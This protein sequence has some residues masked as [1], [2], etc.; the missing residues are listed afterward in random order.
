[1]IRLFLTCFTE[2]VSFQLAQMAGNTYF[3]PY[4]EIDINQQKIAV[5]DKYKVFIDG[6]QTHVASRE[7]FSLLPVVNLYELNNEQPR[8]TINKLFSFF[9]PKYD[10]IR[11]DNNVL[12][13][14]T[15]S[16]WKGQYECPVG[17]D[18]Y[19]I[20]A[21]RGRKYSIY[22]NDQQIAWWNK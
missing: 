17:P 12:E 16:F 20:Y 9:K 19:T 1:M 18:G 15:Q 10:I 13:F 7:I 5:G 2:P 21:H 3:I 14:R 11:W 8:M 6:Q 4:M 22:K